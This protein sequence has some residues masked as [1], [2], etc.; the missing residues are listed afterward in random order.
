MDAVL[1]PILISVGSSIIISILS[2]VM[3]YFSKQAKMYRSL[4]NQNQKENLRNTIR[5]EVEPIYEELVRLSARVESCE[6]REH[7]DVEAILQSYKFRLVYLCKTYLRQGYVTQD[8]FD[9]L[10]EFY[11][12]Y[13][14]LG[15][16]GQAQEYYER[17]SALTIKG[18]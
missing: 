1:I 9:Q 13:H 14:N 4:Y 10:S 6:S 12:V 2:A 16:N 11:K 18:E 5:E 17:A 8:Q 7:R 3:V 15:G